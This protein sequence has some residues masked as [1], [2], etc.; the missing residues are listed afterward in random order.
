MSSQLQ[1]TPGIYFYYWNRHVCYMCIACLQV[2]LF[3]VLIVLIHFHIISSIKPDILFPFRMSK[4]FEKSFCTFRTTGNLSLKVFCSWDFKVC[5]KRSVKMQKV[6]I[7]TQLKVCGNMT[8]VKSTLSSTAM[9]KLH[10]VIHK[11]WDIWRHVLFCTVR[12]L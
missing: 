1:H 5:R 7:C 8:H 12:K 9:I 2:C 11:C 6:N 4:S 3:S 10:Y